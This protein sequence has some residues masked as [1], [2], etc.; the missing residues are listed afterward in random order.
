MHTA[1]LVVKLSHIISVK[2]SRE[3]VDQL[4]FFTEFVKH[5]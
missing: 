2:I 3:L 1:L 4:A 5:N